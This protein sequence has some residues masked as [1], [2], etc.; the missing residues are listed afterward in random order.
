MSSNPLISMSSP[1]SHTLSS[2]P[3]ISRL[4]REIIIASPSTSQ[5]RIDHCFVHNRGRTLAGTSSGRQARRDYVVDIADQI[6]LSDMS[7]A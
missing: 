7:Q 6:D 2:N 4:S 1:S 5:V 3:P